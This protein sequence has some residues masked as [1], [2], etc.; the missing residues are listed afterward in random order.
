MQNQKQG[1]TEEVFMQFSALVLLVGCS[2]RTNWSLFAVVRL[3][4]TIADVFDQVQINV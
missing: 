1:T 3:E 2:S 4:S